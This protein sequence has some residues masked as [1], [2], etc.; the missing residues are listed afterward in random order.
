[1]AALRPYNFAASDGPAKRDLAQDIHLLAMIALIDR[2]LAEPDLAN[3]RAA[4][5]AVL[6]ALTDAG[7]ANLITHGD[8]SRQLT[9]HH[10]PAICFGG[11]YGLLRNWQSNA[12]NHLAG[13][14]T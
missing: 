9:L 10:I 1:M 8:D 13:R 7:L 11:P 12:R 3:L 4:A 6:T 2:E 5:S 14:Q